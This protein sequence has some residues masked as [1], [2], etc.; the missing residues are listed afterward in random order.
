MK[1]AGSG[2]IVTFVPGVMLPN[3]KS[4]NARTYLRPVNVTDSTEP[5]NGT[6]ARLDGAVRDERPTLRSRLLRDRVA[7]VYLEGFHIPAPCTGVLP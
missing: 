2:V 5:E 6:C 1:P 3:V 4:S 7:R